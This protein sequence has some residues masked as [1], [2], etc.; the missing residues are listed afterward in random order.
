MAR[1]SFDKVSVPFRG[2]RSEM[3][4]ADFKALPADEFPSPFGVHV[5]KSWHYAASPYA[6]AVS[7]PFRGSRSEIDPLQVATE[8]LAVVSVP[9]RGSRSEMGVGTSM[10][11]KFIE[12]P[13]PFG[14]HVL[15]F[16]RKT[17]LRLRGFLFPSPFGVHVLKWLVQK[18][19]SALKFVSVPFRGSRSEMRLSIATTPRLTSCFRPLSGFT[20]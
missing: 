9:F 8:K 20:F 7:V 17:S 1:I 10:T 19:V 14:V 15:K 16:R 12:F 13:S 3:L 18:A 6:G 4:L 2:S 11:R 5:L